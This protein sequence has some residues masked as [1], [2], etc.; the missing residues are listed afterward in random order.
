MK[1]NFKNIQIADI[2][3]WKLCKELNNKLKIK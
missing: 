2:T 3:C 1:P